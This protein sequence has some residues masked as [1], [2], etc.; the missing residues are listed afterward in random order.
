MRRLPAIA[1]GLLLA[2][3]GGGLARAA[4]AAPVSKSGA[5]AAQLVSFGCQRNLQPMLRA[6]SVTGVMR[7]VAGTAHMQMRFDLMTSQRRLGRYRTLR[8]A[9]LGVWLSPRDPTLG[10]HPDDQWQV[11]HPVVEPPAPA[12]YKFRVSFRWLDKDSHRLAQFTLTSGICH[13]LELRPDLVAQSLTVAPAPMAGQDDFLALVRDQGL[14]GAGPVEVQL[15]LPD[16]TKATR[17]ILWLGAH[18]AREIQFAAPACA[19]GSTLTLSVDPGMA[20]DDFDRA[21]NTLTVSC[22]AG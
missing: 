16:G 19:A 22:P 4:G 7:P 11:P 17:Q 12:F 3:G 8:G 9:N 10:T 6:V 5:P 2:Q 1:A 20:V 15:T 13:Q 14:T 18:R 21:N